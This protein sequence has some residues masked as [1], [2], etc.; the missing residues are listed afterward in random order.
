MP[1]DWLKNPCISSVRI[2]KSAMLPEEKNA[3]VNYSLKGR[4]R[5]Y[6]SWNI[7]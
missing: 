1:D 6:S 5:C 4:L 2:A 7:K 3:Q